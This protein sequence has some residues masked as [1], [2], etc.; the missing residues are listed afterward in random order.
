MLEKI[1]G[2]C[3]VNPLFIPLIGLAVAVFLW[4]GGLS[5][6]SSRLDKK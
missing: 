1:Y 3:M 5:I 2:I 4:S 6:Q